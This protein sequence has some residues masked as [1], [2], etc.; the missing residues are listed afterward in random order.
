M[1]EQM[2][3]ELAHSQMKELGIENYF[4]RFRHLHLAPNLKRT[5]RGENE[6]F[7]LISEIND[8]T[9]KSKAGVYNLSDTAAS[10]MQ[11]IH[12][13]IISIEN[14]G[15]SW[16]EVKLLQVIPKKESSKK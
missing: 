16:A 12:R 9:I 11:H 15:T 7:Y 1:T 4:F 6:F 10:E 5:L 2:A 13:G 8:V 3:I 14:T